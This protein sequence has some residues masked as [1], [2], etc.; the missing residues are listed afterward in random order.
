MQDMLVIKLGGMLLNSDIAM[1]NFFK[2][3]YDYK[4]IDR[5]VLIVHG[6]TF[7][8]KSLLRKKSKYNQNN[9]FDNLSGDI[10]MHHESKCNI[11]SGIINAHVMKYAYI[12]GMNA[13]GLHCTDG[14][15]VIFNSVNLESCIYVDGN[16]LELIN[17]LFSRNIIPIISPT[18]FTK[19]N[20]L[21]NID[22]DIVSMFLA[23]AL[24]ARLIMLTDV[25][26]VLDGKGHEIRKIN[27]LMYKKLILEGVLSAGMVT[28]VHAALQV[29][30]FLNQPVNIS[31]WTDRLK[32]KKIL[33][34]HAIGT[35]IVC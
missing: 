24:K 31:S 7:W 5:N 10:S 27:T 12:H 19:D 13:L 15:T 4:T 11:L 14:N 26:G 23:K 17:Y 8:V 29:C 28:K 1:N 2:V 16:S 3:L 32:L 21:I 33:C 18:G 34:G 9:Y 6:G 22:A 35:T 25:S 20:F 30:K